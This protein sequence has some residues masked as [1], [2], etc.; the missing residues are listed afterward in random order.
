MIRKEFKVDIP[1]FKAE[2]APILDGFDFQEFMNMNKE[3]IE[4]E[5]Y[6][7]GWWYYVVLKRFTNTRVEIVLSRTNSISKYERCKRPYPQCYESC[8]VYL[9]RETKIALKKDMKF[10]KNGKYYFTDYTNNI[11]PRNYCVYCD[12]G[13]VS[14]FNKHLRRPKHVKNVKKYI[15]MLENVLN[16]NTDVVK[17]IYSFLE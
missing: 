7:N 12:T 3:R 15:E 4:K 8:Y 13:I 16:I 2:L 6:L 14:A 9:T 5:F 17:Y 10:G 11:L 1:K